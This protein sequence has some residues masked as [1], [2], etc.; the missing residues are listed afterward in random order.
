MC[1]TR[2]VQGVLT[3]VWMMTNTVFV[4]PQDQQ[5][6][7]MCQ[8]GTQM[9]LQQWQ[10]RFEK[11]TV[12]FLIAGS[13]T[14]LEVECYRLLQRVRG[15]KIMWT[16]TG[17][18]GQVLGPSPAMSCK[19]WCQ[20]WWG[21]WMKWLEAHGMATE[22]LRR[23]QELDRYASGDHSRIFEEATMSTH[24]SLLL[25]AKF[26]GASKGKKK[27]VS[28]QLAWRAALAAFVGRFLKSDTSFD[29]IVFLDVAAT[30]LMGTHTEGSNP[31]R[32]PVRGSEVEM[33]AL[34]TCDEMPVQNSL[35]G[36]PED[37]KTAKMSLVEVLML[38]NDAGRKATWLHKQ[39]IH[40]IGDY[41]EQS[42]EKEAKTLQRHQ[43]VPVQQAQ[44]SEE[45]A[46][47]L[48]QLSANQ[49][50]RNRQKR[51]LRHRPGLRPSKTSRQNQK[52][53]R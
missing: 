25:F 19:R 44:Q 1:E 5:L 13:S 48:Q 53:L 32:L 49:E 52:V 24:A 43:Q 41:I 33:V 18:Y 30:V 3:K 51:Q 37:K 47:E 26:A 2:L 38:V 11:L 12:S 14:P 29:M 16:L 31:I 39:L 9:P 27:D 20:S 22:H 40:H 4:H 36:I 10:R 28:T 17:W 42:M 45:P 6:W 8:D 34:W 15:S 7:V 46:M 21:W 50:Q 35:G 23:P